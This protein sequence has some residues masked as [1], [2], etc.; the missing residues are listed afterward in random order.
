MTR[1]NLTIAATGLSRAA[2]S[3]TQGSQDGPMGI[4][5]RADASCARYVDESVARPRGNG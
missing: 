5:P 4:G 3:A 2:R 1:M